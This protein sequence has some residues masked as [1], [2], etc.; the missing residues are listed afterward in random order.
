MLALEYLLKRTNLP[1][2]LEMDCPGQTCNRRLR[3]AHFGCGSGNTCNFDG[4]CV[5]VGGGSTERRTDGSGSCNADN[6]SP[7]DFLTTEETEIT[8]D[9]DEDSECDEGY[10]CKN[11]NKCGTDY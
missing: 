11:K 3:I 7:D 9:C 6:S 1:Q 4:C 10:S 5:P 8:C 2:I